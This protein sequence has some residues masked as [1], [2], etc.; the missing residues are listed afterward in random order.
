LTRL[1]FRQV[2]TGYEGLVI[3]NINYFLKVFSD[4]SEQAMKSLYLVRRS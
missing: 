3:H 1:S 2:G 4:K